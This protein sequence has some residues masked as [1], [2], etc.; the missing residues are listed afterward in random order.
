[1]DDIVDRIYVINMKKDTERLKQFK[2]QVKDLFS[3]EIY[4]GVDITDKKQK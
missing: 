4:E 3:Y 1:M 2:E